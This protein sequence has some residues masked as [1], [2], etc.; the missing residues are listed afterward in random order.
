[1]HHLEAWNEMVCDGAWGATAARLGERLRRGMD[2]DHWAAFKLSFER[3]TRLIAEI[4]SGRRG[5]PPA[6]IVVLSGDVHHAYL[7]EVAFPGSADV[8]SAVYQATCSPFRNPLDRRERRAIK[9]MTGFAAERLTR[10]LARGA[11]ARA[12]E[13]KWRLCEGP[14]FDNQVGTLRIDGREIEARLDKTKPGEHHEK[15]LDR[16][17]ERTIA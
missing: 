17:F 14:Y 5:R 12:P 11:G 6:S 3:L 15:E 9:A 2:F 10:A 7:A 16:T 13:I 1:M 4:G 8:R